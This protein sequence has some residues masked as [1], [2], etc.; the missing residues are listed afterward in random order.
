MKKHKRLIIGGVILLT[1]LVVAGIWGKNFYYNYKLKHLP[2]VVTPDKPANIEPIRVAP[3]TPITD[4]NELQAKI[5]EKKWAE[6]S[7]LAIKYAVNEIHGLSQRIGAY[8]YCVYAATS[9]GDSALAGDCKQKATV[10]IATFHAQKD[11][12][13]FTKLFEATSK[14]EKVKEDTPVQKPAVNHE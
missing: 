9:I 7:P 10:L 13:N 12:D 4:Y 11:K 8:G 2:G 5:A 6:V 1:L 14:N 3:P